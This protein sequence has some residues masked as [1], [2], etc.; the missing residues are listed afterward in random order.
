MPLGVNDGEEAT[1]VRPPETQEAFFLRVFL[2]ADDHGLV[3]EHL[4]DFA[5]RRPVAG[6]VFDVGRVPI[7][8]QAYSVKTV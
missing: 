4:L 3:R 8:L 2:N 6:D 5:G 1:R 7:E